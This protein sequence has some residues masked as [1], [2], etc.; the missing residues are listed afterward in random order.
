MQLG[1]DAW[2]D[3]FNETVDGLKAQ[4]AL[5]SETMRGIIAVVSDADDREQAFYAELIRLSNAGVD[6][7]GLLDQYGA[8]A[9]SLLKGTQSAE[10]LYAALEQLENLNALQT[11]LEHADALSGAAKAINP[12]NESYDP[13][14]TLQAY[15]LLEAE[16]AE[17]TH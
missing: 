10:E 6:S 8:L 2:K 11:D 5:W 3:Y 9:I 13:T 7:S 1:K 15:A 16:Y 12:A 4:S 17:L 14:S